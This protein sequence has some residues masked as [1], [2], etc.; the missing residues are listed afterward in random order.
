MDSLAV[1]SLKKLEQLAVRYLAV[2]AWAMTP[3]ICLG[4]LLTGNPLWMEATGFSLILSLAS[5][6][7]KKDKDASLSTKY[8]LASVLTIQTSILLGVFSGHPWQL[9]IHMLFFA[10]LAGISMMVDWRPI[11][12]STA[13]VALHHLLLS[14]VLPSLVFPDLSLIH[15]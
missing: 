13:F 7:T 12:L 1:I 6:Y 10:V 9:D 14:F 4:A 11:F 2:S 8:L 3:I 15:I 5:L